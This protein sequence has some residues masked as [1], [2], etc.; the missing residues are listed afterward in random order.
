[1]PPPSTQLTSWARPRLSA[2][3]PDLDDASLTQ[4]LEY[5]CSLDAAR[6]AEHL[7]GIL[8]DSARALE[9]IVG[10][11]E[12]RGRGAAGAG[13][14][15]GD[16]GKKT[17]KAGG[18]QAQA[19]AE[20]KPPSAAG[21]L[22]S[23][24][25]PNV[26]SK[27]ARAS[28]ARRHQQQQQQQHAASS[29]STEASPSRNR[30]V[31]TAAS[32]TTSTTSDIADLTAAIA[33]LEQTTNPSLSTTTSTSNNPRQKRKCS[34]QATLHPLFT[35]APNCLN[36]GKIICA[37]EGLQPCS[38]CQHPPLSPR[39]VQEMIRELRAERGNEKMRAHN[40]AAGSKGDRYQHHQQQHQQQQQQQRH[41]EISSNNSG[42]GTGTGTDTNDNTSHD[43]AAAQAHRDKLLR[44][45]AQN[46]RRT[47][48]VDEVAEFETP[49]VHAAS[50]L[51]MSAGQ[52]ALA[53]KRQQR[54]LRE[55]E[56]K[57]RERERGSVVVSLS[58]EGGRKGVL[59]RVERGVVEEGEQEE[60]REEEQVEEVEEVEVENGEQKGG[61]GR[62]PLLAG[63][64]LVRPVWKPKGQVA[65]WNGEGGGGGKERE[66]RQKKQT[67]RRVQDDDG[68]NE[69]WILDGGLYGFGSERGDY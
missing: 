34:C 41:G 10:F 69:R 62:N 29:P 12:R 22:I 49:D 28:V 46:A 43:L 20:R 13:A 50:T 3:L 8:G 31:S 47:R 54:V 18:A 25:L 56:E 9:F 48:V 52:R 64:G 38:F 65:D 6:A 57:E 17:G 24:Y 61:F 14:G 16:G 63:G 2:L 53:L 5:T 59:R 45:Q 67:W 55:M 11:G 4:L 44:F 42:P 15:G 33:Q 68:D 32:T 51:W 19:Q 26:R 66:P 35:P 60:E 7:R 1:M 36:C 30:N 21:P 23:E 58:F 39:Q 27:T 37:L 40:L